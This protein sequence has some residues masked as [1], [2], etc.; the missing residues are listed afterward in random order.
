MKRP[1][2]RLGWEITVT[3]RDL[4]PS[5]HDPRWNPREPDGAVSPQAYRARRPRAAARPVPPPRRR[6][7]PSTVIWRWRW[8]LGILAGV[9]LL[10]W[11]S[12]LVTGAWVLVMAPIVVSSLALIRPCQELLS[13]RGS[14][15]AVQHRIRTGCSQAGLRGPDGELPAVLWTKAVAHGERISLRRPPTVTIEDFRAERKRLARACRA[16]SVRVGRHP[17]SDQIVVLDVFRRGPDQTEAENLA[18]RR[19]PRPR[20]QQEA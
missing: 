6:P 16:Q 19:L 11:E 13:R 9:A 1:V 4:G 8:E 2:R 7:W 12:W 17:K 3:R 10:A 14:A 15:I 18:V 5:H 20:Q